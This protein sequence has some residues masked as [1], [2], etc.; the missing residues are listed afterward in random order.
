MNRLTDFNNRSANP[1]LVQAVLFAVIISIYFHFRIN[2]ID[3]PLNRDEGGFAFFGRL[4]SQGG[5]LYKDGVDHKPPGIWLIYAG[6]SYLVPFT[7]RGL[8]WTIHIYNLVTLVLFGLLCIK[9]F[10]RKTSF[11]ATLIFAVVTSGPDVEGSSA[12]AE[13]FMLLPIVASFLLC[14]MGREKDSFILVYLS[15]LFSGIAF[16]IK[17]PAIVFSV[18]IITCTVLVNISEKKFEAYDRYNK[19]LKLI[20]PFSLGFITLSAAILGYFYFQGTWDEFIYWSFVHNLQYASNVSLDFVFRI[21][22]VRVEF[23]L[24]RNPLIWIIALITCIIIPFA[25]PVKGFIVTGFFLFSLMSVTHSW[26]MYR[27]YFAL[28]CPA[29]SLA[30]GVGISHT[31]ALWESRK[32]LRKFMF[33]LFVII[34]VVIPLLINS[35]FYISNSPAQNSKLCFS[36]NPFPESPLVAE[37]LRENT[38]PADT[39]LILGSEPQILILAD[40]KSATRHPFFYQVVGPYERSK[41]FQKQVF[42]DIEKN[43]PEYVVAVHNPKSW[44]ADPKTSKQFIKDLNTLLNKQYKLDAIVIPDSESAKIIGCDQELDFCRNFLALSKTNIHLYEQSM[45]LYRK[46][47]DVSTRCRHRDASCEYAAPVGV[48]TPA[49]ELLCASYRPGR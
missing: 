6:L 27:H 19:L 4:I 3:I 11:W 47:L 24:N 9:L 36:I 37:Y 30:G 31:M 1:V 39:I 46:S 26:Q 41:E 15:G 33:L 18:F 10:D 45:T 14:I 21:L 44:V 20:S 23:I 22:E 32:Y 42:E 35:D 16:W 25:N 13:M 5:A 49:H 7:A 38:K 28:I 17:Q 2:L 29:L 48:P 34:V 8:H 40:R 12:S 43:K